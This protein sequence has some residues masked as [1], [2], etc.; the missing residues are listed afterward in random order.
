IRA[1][2]GAYAKRHDG[3]PGQA[4]VRRLTSGEYCY[5][6]KD[7]TGLDL[8]A[9]I[10]ATSDSVGGEGFTNFGDVQFMQDA[11]LERYLK[12]AKIIACDAVI[13]SGPLEFFPHRGKT[14]F[15]LS[16]VTRIKDIY[17]AY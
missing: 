15:E 5:T 6:I 1:E 9:G 13:A 7:L 11:N 8:N 16:A 10:D 14:G 2:L 3:D 4:P 17:A 12:A